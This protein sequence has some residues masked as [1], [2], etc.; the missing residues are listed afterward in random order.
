MKFKN[1]KVAYNRT[2]CKGVDEVENFIFAK[3]SIRF[4]INTSNLCAGNGPL[5]QAMQTIRDMIMYRVGNRTI[6]NGTI[7][8]RSY[9]EIGPLARKQV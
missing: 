4:A 8:K 7:G 9:A 3:T 6:A 1:Q 2:K 5:P